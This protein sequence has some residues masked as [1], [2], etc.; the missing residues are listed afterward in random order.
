MQRQAASPVSGTEVRAFLLGRLQ[1][2]RARAQRQQET[3]RAVAFGPGMSGTP[4]LRMHASSAVSCSR[5]CWRSPGVCSTPAASANDR[6]ALSADRNCATAT[7]GSCSAPCGQNHRRAADQESP[8]ARLTHARTERQQLAHDRSGM[9]AAGRAAASAG[10]GQQRDPGHD[11]RQNCRPPRP[12]LF[13]AGAPAHLRVLVVLVVGV[14]LA[15]RWMT[16]LGPVIRP[17][18]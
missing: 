6:Q 15:A 5:C 4:C 11:C 16:M 14:V 1:L 10:R 12:I 17:W 7:A 18:R 13:T 3:L 9:R 2:R 8:A